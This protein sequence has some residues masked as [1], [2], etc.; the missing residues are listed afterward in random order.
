MALFVI[1]CIDNP[2]S[3]E[4]RAANRPAHLEYYSGQADRV[5]VA[6]PFLGAEGQAVGS[7]VIAE[8]EDQA[9]AEAMAAADP[10][11]KAGLF[12]SVDVRPWRVV[13]G[14]LAD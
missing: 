13:L 4:L 2:D 7:M 9:A 11:N 5:K 6:G 3:A 1:T 8:A 14:A 12:Q 10:Y